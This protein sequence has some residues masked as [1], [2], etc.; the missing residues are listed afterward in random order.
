MRPTLLCIGHRGAMGH[1]PENTLLSIRKALQMGAPAIEIDVFQV[2][3][4]LIVIHDETLDRTTNGSGRL[5]DHD[6]A[7]LRSLD[8]GQGERIP[9]LLEVCNAIAG[10][11]CLNIELKGA[12]TAPAVVKLLQSLVNQADSP[13][14]LEQFT[15]S[16]FNHRTLQA[17]KALDAR[18]PVSVLLYGLPVDDAK[19][20]SSLGAVSVNPSLEFIDERFVM[21]A[22]ARGVRVFV[23]TVNELADLERM[24]AMG[25]DGVFTNY[26]DRVLEN[27]EQPDLPWGWKL[28]P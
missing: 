24:A 11:A 1:A 20:G 9:T 28:R 26:P 6:L 3:D 19:I 8:A 21:D 27:Y 18:I 14:K 7:Y 2:D 4:E 16:S 23:Y 5:W 13:W 22:H 10:R 25:V 15:I 17:V 12:D